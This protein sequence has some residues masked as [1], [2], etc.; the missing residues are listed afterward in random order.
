[1][2][3]VPTFEYATL[4]P[5]VPYT[6]SVTPVAPTVDVVLFPAVFLA[7][8]FK[9]V[10][11]IAPVELTPPIGCPDASVNDNPVAVNLAVLLLP[12]FKVNVLPD[13]VALLPLNNT[14]PVVLSAF[15]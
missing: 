9:L 5:S 7:V 12:S 8:I 13:N 6:A 2:P 10:P 14:F 11:V 15:T 4:A 1:M 3:P